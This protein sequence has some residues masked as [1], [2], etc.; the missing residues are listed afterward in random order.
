MNAAKQSVVL[1]IVLFATTQLSMAGDDKPKYATLTNAQAVEMLNSIE[2]SIKDNYYDPK[3]RGF[4]LKATFDETRKKIAT[5]Q[6]QDDAFL[7]IAAAVDALKDSHTRFEPP[8][9]PYTVEY[10]FMTEAIGDTAC[11]VEAVLAGSDAEAQG[12]KPGDQV[13]SI[14]GV[15]L[16]RQNLSTIEFAY[17]VFPQSGFHLV[18]RSPEGK[19]RAVT[20]RAQVTPGQK[21]I[22]EF[23]AEYWLKTH[24]SIEDRKKFNNT[25]NQSRTFEVD[26][27]VLFWQ[28][29]SFVVDPFDLQTQLDKARNYP[30]LV[31]DLRGN[32][33]GIVSSDNYLLDAFFDHE[34]TAWTIQKRKDSKPNKV[35]GRGKKA[36]AGKLIVLIDSE[37]A[38]A[39]ELFARTVQLQKRGTI[40]GDRS[41]G[42]VMEAESFRSAVYLNAR[43]VTQYGAQITIANLIMP[44]GKSLEGV[45]VTPDEL[46]L[47]TPPDLAAHRDPVLARAA[48]LAGVEM[49][50]EKAGTL[51]PFKWPEKP[52]EMK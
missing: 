7:M 23:D 51:F 29:R 36:F 21:M 26:K 24:H 10:G 50:P 45:G 19:E 25:D 42:A 33:G 16:V 11:Y 38:S 12:L 32:H 2:K 3:L 9:R 28:L 52:H 34:F 1:F 17:R 8:A 13:V 5:A 35:N 47:P 6:S 48:A 43:D 37:S 27:Q 18:V 15:P 20:V 41:A 49:S 14:N 30:F 4:D 31:L 22:S 40:L 44:D 39:S 46:I